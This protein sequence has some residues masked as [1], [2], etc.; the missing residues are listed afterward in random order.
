MTEKKRS[1]SFD[2]SIGGKHDRAGTL[3]AGHICCDVFLFLPWHFPLRIFASRWKKRRKRM[4]VSRIVLISVKHRRRKKT[5]DNEAIQ[6]TGIAHE[7]RGASAL[8]PLSCEQVVGNSR[9]RMKGRACL[10]RREACH[11]MHKERG[12]AIWP[13]RPVGSSCWSL[14]KC[15]ALSFAIRVPN[16]SHCP[17][18]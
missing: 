16:W 2:L 7:N 5:S 4:I 17:R 12:A 13:P 18:R 14:N 1:A 6:V 11:S 3:Y 9:V 15:F 10:V 8:K